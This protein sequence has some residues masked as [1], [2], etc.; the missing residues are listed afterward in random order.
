M[1]SDTK[2][3]PYHHSLPG[4]RRLLRLL[5]PLFAAVLILSSPTAAADGVRQ[6]LSLCARALIPALFPFL[7][8]A[9]MTAASVSAL[10][11]AKSR[12]AALLISFVIGMFCGFPIGAVTLA[13]YAREGVLSNR[14]LRRFTAV[15]S[16]PSPAFLIGYVGKNLLGDVRLGCALLLLLDLVSLLVFLVLLIRTPRTRCRAAE[17]SDPAAAHPLSDAI[18]HGAKTM[19]LISGNVIFFSVVRALL[20][21]YGESVLPRSVLLLLG[22]L[23]EMSGGLSALT[24]LLSEGTLCLR[25]VYVLTAALLAFGGISVGMQVTAVLPQ[26]AADSS[27]LR[28]YY[29]VKCV[30][31]LLC[32]LLASLWFSLL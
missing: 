25:C 1:Q 32:A 9:P 12:H 2:V 4:P 8:L 14:D 30:C 18:A 31:A 28:R 6:G 15:V 29:A 10:T 26:E 11:G 20:T 22:G 16:G 3:M 17:M 23:C 19:L 13:S 21:F 5:L 7:C 24:A 27:F